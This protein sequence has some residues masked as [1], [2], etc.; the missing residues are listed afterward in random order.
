[1]II[2]QPLLSLRLHSVNV[3]ITGG[4]GEC[5]W[6]FQW[7]LIVTHVTQLYA[8]AQLLEVRDTLVEDRSQATICYDDAF[9]DAVFRSFEP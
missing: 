7:A 6:G 2:N 5:A 1:M 9:C 4:K 3:S 8:G